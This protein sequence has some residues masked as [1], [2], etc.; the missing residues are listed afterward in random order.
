MSLEFYSFSKERRGLSVLLDVLRAVIVALVTF[1]VL[2]QLTFYPGGIIAISIALIGMVSF[3]DMRLSV[4]LVGILVFI[5][6]F[7]YSPI[8]AIVSALGF[9]AFSGRLTREKGNGFIIFS[10]A[11]A[12]SFIKF[13]L[14]FPILAAYYFGTIGGI[15]A[16]LI[17]FSLE[18]VGLLTGHPLQGL[19]VSGQAQ[20]M[21]KATAVAVKDLKW[22]APHLQSL[23]SIPKWTN[24]GKMFIDR[25]YLIVQPLIWAGAVAV[26]GKIISKKLSLIWAGVFSMGVIFAIV[27][28]IMA[29]WA[30]VD[31]SFASAVG[32]GLIGAI[33]SGAWIS[34][35]KLI[36]NEKEVKT[37]LTKP[38]AILVLDLCSSTEIGDR[39]G[40]QFSFEL[41]NDLKA[42]VDTAAYANDVFFKKGTGDGF[43]MT[44][45]T[46]E[47]AIKT[48]REILHQTRIR[49][50]TV[51]EDKRIHLRFGGNFGEVQIARDEDRHG[52]AVNVAFRF[53]GI[54]WD[55]IVDPCFEKHQFPEK[56]RVFVS[57]YMARD[58]ENMKGLCCHKIGYCEI[59]GI[60]G[61]H[62]VYKVSPKNG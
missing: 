52:T 59:R 56:D 19:V 32:S 25:P 9:S 62:P 42:I 5:P 38:E 15:L 8:V 12:A 14:A 2:N 11:V 29:S 20:P 40:D 30:S 43:L 13:E 47:Q 49:N 55:N 41:K 22:V 39:F 21:L 1:L 18:I 7:Y 35:S 26:F 17:C 48:A 33:L 23:I 50:E 53:E 57:E 3:I 37:S 27:Q 10:L 54:K 46:T 16:A 60:S 28:F 4:G 45:Q 6:L 36:K 58:I 24:F 44:F 61:R 51:S 34:A 31:F